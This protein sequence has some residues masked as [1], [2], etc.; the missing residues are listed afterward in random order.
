MAAKKKKKTAARPRGVRVPDVRYLI[1]LGAD[2]RTIYITG[3]V[4]TLANPKLWQRIFKIRGPVADVVSKT[5]A[6]SDRVTQVALLGGN[7]SAGAKGG[8]LNPLIP[9]PIPHPGKMDE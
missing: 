9:I 7:L 1:A 4:V 8:E 5:Y 2:Q 6:A 3:E